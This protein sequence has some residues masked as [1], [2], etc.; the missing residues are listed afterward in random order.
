MRKSVLVPVF[1]GVLLACAAPRA[2]AQAP[3]GSLE[4]AARIT[5]TA[6]RPE[7]VRQFTFYILTKSYADIAKE[8]EGKDVIPTR[9]AF[10]DDLK[11]SSEMREWLKAHDIMD[12]TLP[13]FDK[14]VTPDDIIKVPEFLIAY[15]RSNSG[16][17][18]NGI[19][20]PKYAEK[21]KTENPERYKKQNQEYLSALKKFMTAH[22]ESIAGMELELDGVNPQRKWAAVQSE[23]RR[24]VQ[25]IAPEVAQTK[26]LVTKTDT[27][28]EGHAMI[29]GLPPGNY[30]ISSLNLDA[31]AGDIRLRWD[32][33]VTIEAGKAT[34]LELTNL[35]CTDAHGYTP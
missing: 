18:T 21:D 23:H 34:R 33:P 13:G 12:I 3:G 19:P 31:S 11:V 6:A 14:A 15:Q 22:P 26:Y 28:Y 17:V 25:R 2:E 16:G 7:L 32:V 24:R 27:D 1:A 29:N 20:K 10:I 30:W 4:F 9:E 35:N 5:P 8:V